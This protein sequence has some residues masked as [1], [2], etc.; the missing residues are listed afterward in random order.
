MKSVCALK[1][2][3]THRVRAV[4]AGRWGTD[5]VLKSPY[6]PCLMAAVLLSSCAAGVAS[7][8]REASSESPTVD[9][10]SAG[11][12]GDTPDA[13]TIGFS[14]LYSDVPAAGY[15]KSF[16]A[17]RAE[18]VGATLLTD[19]IT[20]GNV[21]QQLSSID[22]YFTRDVD[23]LVVHAVEPSSYAGAIARAEEN[24]VPFVS[25]ATPVPGADAAILFPPDEAARDTSAAVAEWINE[26]LDG[27][28]KVLLLTFT[29]GALATQASEELGRT[30]E[31]ETDALIVGQQD[32]LDQASGLRVTEDVL[33]VHPD[34]NIVI[35][36]ND[37]GAL[38]A[39]RALEDAGKDADEVLVASNEGG[40]EG[41]DALASNPYVKLVSVLSIR[42]IGYAVVDVPMR[43]LAGESAEDE[44][45]GRHLLGK[46]DTQD[47]QRL[48]AEYE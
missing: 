5:A 12:Q 11:T 48:L 9:I 46:D 43:I 1:L 3:S 39:A 15:L 45:V 34:L 32:A 30:V 47:I 35:A 37:G 13:P 25:Y 36:W 19:N 24:G 27:E 23:A 4:S 10:A 16:A 18:E 6:I 20:G 26:N 28:G 29:E 38:G 21:D 22:S 7:D 33:K 42:D 2:S 8:S 14:F 40:Q 17:E 31:E 44:T 41:L